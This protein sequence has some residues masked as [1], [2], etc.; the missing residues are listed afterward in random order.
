[1]A[2]LASAF[3]SIRA[4]CPKKVRRRDLMM[5]AGYA[6]KTLKP[7]KRLAKLYRQEIA[8]SGHVMHS[9]RVL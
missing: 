9:L 7:G 8:A 4:R 6:A 3:S 1:M 2:W 5:D